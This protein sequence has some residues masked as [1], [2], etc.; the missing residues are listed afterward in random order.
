MEQRYSGY[1]ALVPYVFARFVE[2]ASPPLLA[3][4]K[5]EMF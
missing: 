4:I 3:V 5:H 2:P 1:P